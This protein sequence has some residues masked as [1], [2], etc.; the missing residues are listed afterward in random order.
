MKAFYG[1]VAWALILGLVICK[2]QAGADIERQPRL[3][4]PSK[5]QMLHVLAIGSDYLST[6][7]NP[8]T[9]GGD[10]QA[11]AGVFKAG[12]DSLYGAAGV[13]EVLND[14]ATKDNILQAINQAAAYLGPKDTFVFF[15]SGY[16]A[17]REE[18]SYLIPHDAALRGGGK[19]EDSELIPATELQAAL[20]SVRAGHRLFLLDSDYLH[21]APNAEGT[22]VL[23]ASGPGKGRAMQG[24]TYGFFTSVLL[25]ALQG[26]GDADQDGRVS[27]FE[28]AGFAGRHLP[29]QTSGRQFPVIRL[30]GPDFPLVGRP[31]QD[32]APAAVALADKLDDNLVGLIRVHEAEGMA[33]VQAYG[34]EHQIEIPDGLVEVIVYAASTDALDALK[35]EVVRLGG[36]VQTEF[37][38]I[39]YATLPVGALEDFVM[40]EAVWRVDWSRQVYAPPSDAMPSE[41]TR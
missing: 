29:A 4:T 21:V 3:E 39:L 22:H 33:G 30:Y 26:W 32:S 2:G 6:A 41:D 1:G 38:N 12:S 5:R 37:E 34:A 13:V 11:L 23:L 15:F 17:T 10:A 31:G 18:Q 28:L 9:G 35:D 20:D 36:S 16:V 25:Q 19:M 40:Q 7:V 27:V 8:I 14:A 24:R